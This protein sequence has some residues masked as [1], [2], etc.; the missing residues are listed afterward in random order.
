[1]R[2]KSGTTDRHLEREQRRAVERTVI[3]KLV[4][5][6]ILGAV[7]ALPIL[8]A[9]MLATCDQKM[10]HYYYYYYYY[11]YLVEFTHH[12]V[13]RHQ[14]WLSLAV[15]GKRVATLEERAG[16]GFVL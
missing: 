7:P 15:P 5:T 2:G 14:N 4:N 6:V 12:S 1:M 11:Y 8:E 16:V 10:L 3:P 9:Q 13:R